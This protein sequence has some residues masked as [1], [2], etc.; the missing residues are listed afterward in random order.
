MGGRRGVYIRCPDAA[1]RLGGGKKPN[2]SSAAFGKGWAGWDPAAP[3]LP[4][5]SSSSSPSQ[6]RSPLPASRLPR[7][8]RDERRARSPPPPPPAT[9]DGRHPRPREN[10]RLPQNPAQ[11][12]G[13]VF[14]GGRAALRPEPHHQAADRSQ[15]QD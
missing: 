11:R 15:V 13:G 14:Q 12:R 8:G 9:S 1:P 3:P 6:P 7:R 5:P 10:Q 4:P 2:I